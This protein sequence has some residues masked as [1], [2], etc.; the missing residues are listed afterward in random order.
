MD[1]EAI[2][3]RRRTVV[4]LHERGVPHR[5]D[6]PVLATAEYAKL[7]STHD[8]VL[9]S[10]CLFAVMAKGFD[11]P[12]DWYEECLTDSE[13]KLA[14][15]PDENAF[16]ADPAPDQSVADNFTWRGEC[17]LTLLWSIGLIDSLDPPTE[18]FDPDEFFEIFA[19]GWRSK[20]KLRTPSEIYDE[21]DLIY[22]YHWAVVG[23]GVGYAQCEDVLPNVVYERHYAL[24][25]LIGYCNQSWDDIT[26]DT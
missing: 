22:L 19:E 10:L 9:R 2:E 14:F 13:L 25:W 12:L 7:R 23:A 26:T 21:H 16:L 8:V 11:Y 15:S 17:C 1:A 5:D 24:N 3:R 6:L 20:A 4:S 18:Q